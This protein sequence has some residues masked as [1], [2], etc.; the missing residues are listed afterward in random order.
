MIKRIV[1]TKEAENIIHRI[2]Q[3]F[4]EII[5]YQSG[6]C[7]EGSRPICMPKNDYYVKT[8]DALFDTIEGF[9]YYMDKDVIEYWQ[10]SQLTLDVIDSP[11]GGFSLENEYDKSFIIRSRLFSKEEIK[12]LSPIY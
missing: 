1:A 11:S 5:F 3:E 8:K 10:Y 7:C 12:S 4:G 2:A 6:G 9:E